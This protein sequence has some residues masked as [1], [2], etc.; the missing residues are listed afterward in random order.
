MQT[1]PFTINQSMRDQ[2]ANTLTLQAVAHHG[3]RIADDLAALNTQ[4]WAAHRI[5]VEALPGLNKKHWAELIQVGAISGT[6]TCTPSYEEPR[7]EGSPRTVAFVAAAYDYR[8]EARTILVARLLSSPAFEGVQRYLVEN[9]RYERGWKIHLVSTTGSVPR[10]YGME[11]ITDPALETLGLM[12]CTELES[13]I[14]AAMAFRSQAM[15]VLLACRTSRQ[16]EDLFPEAAKLLPQP[17][18]NEKALAPT[19]LAANVRSMLTQ[20]V[21]PVTAQ[22]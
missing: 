1:K 17:V 4:F 20:G 11:G 22:A 3:P 15:D 13:V 7:D 9:S 21:P 2:V 6:A 8:D 18:K 16:L 14:Q 10:L 12:I 5:K 19:E